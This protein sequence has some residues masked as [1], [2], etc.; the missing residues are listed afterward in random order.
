M[1]TLA[2]EEVVD[3]SATPVFQN[4]EAKL[5]RLPLCRDCLDVTCDTGETC[6]RGDCVD[7]SVDIA[8]L[9]ADGEG[10]DLAGECAAD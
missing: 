7:D 1:G 9:P 2:G 8:S 3:R 4:D 10:V 6:R 5:L